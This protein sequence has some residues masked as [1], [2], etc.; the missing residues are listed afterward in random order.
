M[1][2]KISELLTDESKWCRFDPA[3]DKD[4]IPTAPKSPEAVRW[5]L[6]GA[7]SRCGYTFDERSS[8]FYTAEKKISPEGAAITGWQDAPERTFDEVR[9]LLLSIGH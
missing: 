8:F 9:E 7:A 2:K 5:C 4:G 3:R 1:E 6:L